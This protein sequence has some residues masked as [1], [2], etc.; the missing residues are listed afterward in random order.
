MNRGKSGG[1][2]TTAGGC[3]EFLAGER[4]IIRPV[5]GTWWSDPG[6]FKR[7][8][9]REF[10]FVGLLGGLGLTLGD[11]FRLRAAEAA[12]GEA[13]AAGAAGASA[14]AGPTPPAKSVIQ[15]FLP[16]GIASQESFDPKPFAPIEYRGPFNSIAT[17]IDGVRFGEHLKETAG[18]ADRLCV[19]RSMTHGEA[20]HERGTHNM[21]TGYR[22]SPAIQYPS[23]GSIVSHELGGRGALP[24]YVC[25]PNQPNPYAGSGF[26]STAFGPFGVGSD[27][28]N[29]DFT[30]RDLTLPEGV[31]PEHF[32]RR[33]GLLAAVDKHFR[34]LEQAD[35]LSAMDSFYDR[36]YTLISSEEARKAF[37]IRSETDAVR[38]RYGRTQ[39]GQ[40][41]LLA[42]RLVE[43]GVRFVSMT[44]GS[45][46]HHQDIAKGIRDNL[47]P[48]DKALAALIL[49]LE[50][51]GLLDSTLVMV[52][53]EFGRTPKINKDGGRDHWP[54]VF[55]IVMA[56][57]GIRKG[58]AYGS[59]DATASEPETDP[60][61]VEDFAAT[62][63]RQ[64]GVQ[65]EK[66]LMAAGDRPVPIVKGGK[67][68]EALLS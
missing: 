50:E 8:T 5:D 29:K 3:E 18:I 54:R 57:G 6:H 28:A 63:Y 7:P 33:K 4:S 25:I 62:I 46:D 59:S 67:A 12:S 37:D 53:S 52:T 19:I 26:L 43:S 2:R 49:D 27:P 31:S 45:W 36:A 64:I 58:S 15:I 35:A 13:A 24:P 68:V 11:F 20:A 39:A 21:F 61:S 47:P 32:E 30:V 34:S 38:D 17:K 1:S 66:P 22:P 48:F 41:M 44:A 42:R 10:L 23:M 51:R 40:R 16:G 9:R 14:G 60:L 65:S 55:S 56:G